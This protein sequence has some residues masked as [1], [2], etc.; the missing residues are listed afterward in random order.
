VQAGHGTD[1]RAPIRGPGTDSRAFREGASFLVRTVP[2]VS[3]VRP[4]ERRAWLRTL[5]GRLTRGR[6]DWEQ[7]LFRVGDQPVLGDLMFVVARP[8][9]NWRV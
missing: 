4:S 8:I 6:M 9:P 1:K 7:F 3:M 2:Y 5:P